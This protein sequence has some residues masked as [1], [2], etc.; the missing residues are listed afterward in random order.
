MSLQPR[1]RLQT[2]DARAR[3]QAIRE[4][5]E[6]RIETL[7]SQNLELD[8]QI[9]ELAKKKKKN[10]LSKG[11]ELIDKI[12]PGQQSSEKKKAPPKKAAPSSKNS[13]KK[14]QGNQCHDPSTGRF[15][16][17]NKKG[18]WS[19]KNSGTNIKKIVPPEAV[20]IID[21]Y[22]TMIQEKLIDGDVMPKATYSIKAKDGTILK[23]SD[24]DGLGDK[25]HINLM[26]KSLA[27]NHEMNPLTPP[28]HVI[29]QK[30][31]DGGLGGSRGIMGWV[32]NLPRHQNRINISWEEIESTYPKEHFD[33]ADWHGD[34]FMPASRDENDDEDN[35]VTKI[36]YVMAHEYGH[37]V[38]FSKN[39]GSASALFDQLKG[40]WEIA[41]AK[42]DKWED[43][44]PRSAYDPIRDG[45]E[46]SLPW[47]EMSNYGQQSATEAYGEAYAEWMTT[48]G[49]TTSQVSRAYAYYEKWPGWDTDNGP[50][51]Y[52]WNYGDDDHDPGTPYPKNKIASPISQR[53]TTNVNSKN[54]G[55]NLR[56]VS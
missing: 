30:E 21:E 42:F 32:Y 45:P 17:G 49:R 39:R 14:N 53:P 51:V 47:H 15:C 8:S 44:H 33:T 24:M 28:A 52:S 10:L 6:S 34:D 4:Q 55:K 27:Y 25:E 31:Y 12:I 38:D 9:E 40:D 11:K 54:R 20:K 18:T 50:P 46:E 19:S 5:L 16:K 3:R 56:S 1:M 35:V 26:L 29:L 36:Q 43:E 23:I 2:P 37:A 7:S 13:K 22:E 48:S 41:K